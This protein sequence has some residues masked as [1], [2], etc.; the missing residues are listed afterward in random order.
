MSA[1]PI[2]M[3]HSISHENQYMSVHKDNFYRQMKLMIKLGFKSINLKDILTNSNDKNFVITFDDGYEDVYEN[4]L[5]ILQ[6]LGLSATCFFVANNIGT[7]NTWD[8]GKK[9]YKRMKL[10]NKKQIYNWNKNG[11]EVG[12]HS[13]NHK[14]LC[15][16][17]ML[18]KSEQIVKSKIF[19]KENFNID[20]KSF[21]YPFGV[22]DHTCAQLV[23]KDFNFAVTTKRS[24]FKKDKFNLFEIPRIPIN[25]NTSQFK[26][27]LK[28][29]TFYEDIKFR[30]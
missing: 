29:S 28:V 18:D 19:F 24:R 2:L 7:F 11:F 21:S 8:Q 12:S 4:A 27:F 3:Y 1:I 15:D 23:K 10:M 16:L 6:E 25:F 13:L 26:F 20:V 22:Y 14:N 9:K 5:P 30:I 17:N